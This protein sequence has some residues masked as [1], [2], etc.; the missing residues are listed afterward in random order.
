VRSGAIVTAP[1]T[2][3]VSFAAGILEALGH[4]TPE[5]HYYCNLYGAEHLPA[6]ANP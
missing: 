1:G 6:A 4:G 5:L 3:P 2:A